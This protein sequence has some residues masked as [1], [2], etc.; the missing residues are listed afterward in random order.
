MLILITLNFTN[1]HYTLSN[2]QI[3]ALR[4]NEIVVATIFLTTL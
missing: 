4:E 3:L 2:F 1:I